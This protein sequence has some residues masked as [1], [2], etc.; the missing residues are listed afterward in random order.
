MLKKKNSVERKSIDAI[1]LNL[2]IFTVKQ[3]YKDL[4]DHALIAHLINQKFKLN[5]TKEHIDNFYGFNDIYVEN[6][7]D[8]SR[9]QFYKLQI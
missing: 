2:Y 1:S 9:K 6:F 8:E 4:S 5:I 7:E 3:Q